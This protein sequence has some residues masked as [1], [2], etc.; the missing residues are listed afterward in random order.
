MRKINAVIPARGGSKRIHRKNLALINN[1]PL[2]AYT[3]ELC[4]AL[5][6]VDRVI[7]STDDKEIAKVSL[8][9]GAEIPFM[10]PKAYSLDMSPDNDFLKHF[11]QE[12]GCEEALFLRPTTPFRE[13]VLVSQAIK[14]FWEQEDTITGFRSVNLTGDNPYKMF[15][16]DDDNMCH[17]FFDDFKGIKDYSNLPRQ[18]FPQAY[19]ANGYVDL[20]KRKTLFTQN[21][22]YGARIY[23]FITPKTIDIDLPDDL[24]LAN[25]YARNK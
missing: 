22:V 8:N 5:D 24:K 21:S 17:G 19:Q 14:C 10:R 18:T 25:V 12:I 11:F 3:I 6:I 4:R 20:I 23:G 7:V 1:K 9:Y 15:Q 2:I 13:P 16:M